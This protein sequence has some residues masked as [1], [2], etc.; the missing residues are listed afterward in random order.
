M[1]LEL[2]ASLTKRSTELVY[3]VGVYA[4]G[5]GF[6]LLVG[7]YARIR[8]LRFA[9]LSTLGFG[10]VLIV[11]LG[12]SVLSAY[13][14]TN[15][16]NSAVNGQ[17]VLLAA[18]TK[19]VGDKLPGG[20]SD[21]NLKQHATA[22]LSIATAA[23]GSS[24][25]A[26]TAITDILAAAPAGIKITSIQITPTAP[27]ATPAVT[28]ATS[29]KTA[30][31]AVKQTT[32]KVAI[33]AQIL[34]LAQV[35]NWVSSVSQLNFLTSVDST[36]DNKSVSTTAQLVGMQPASLATLESTWAAYLPKARTAK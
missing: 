18:A 11:Y 10:A 25:D 29:T 33:T 35:S 2:P 5:H 8:R 17:K 3:P 30:T 4:P 19:A 1:K 34:D 14:N 22:R 27:A 16:N 12:V 20:I 23:I 9:T 31:P 28:S 13:V 26:A 32:F 36:N 6:D 15:L 21:D 7:G 24:V